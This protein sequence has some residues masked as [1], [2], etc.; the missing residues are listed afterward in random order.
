MSLIRTFAPLTLVSLAA[1]AAPTASAQVEAPAPA[2]A[3]AGQRSVRDQFEWDIMNL[4]R[5]EFLAISEANIDQLGTYR[6]KMVKQERVD[7]KLLEAQEIITTVQETP[8]AVRLDFAAGP[9]KGRVILYNSA[10]KKD[11]FRVRETGFLSIV[12]A[13]W[14]DVDSGFAKKESNH[15]ITDSGLG[16]LARRFRR[17][18]ARSLAEGGFVE[19]HEGW[20]TKGS[21][22]GLYLSP[23]GGKGWDSFSTRIC[24]DPVTRFP[25]KVEAFDAAGR[26]TERYEFSNVEK[27]TLPKD[28]FTLEGAGL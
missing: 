11:R 10:L 14:L 8:F 7:G 22:C 26:L 2:A 9:G 1:F 24:T 5:M 6:M 17:D 3:D 20:N 4:G 12:G 23:N 18:Q 13:I 27:V 16:S 19:K 25:S 15:T 21:W 28:Y